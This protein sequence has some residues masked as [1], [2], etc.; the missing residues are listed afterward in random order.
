[1]PHDTRPCDICGTTYAPMYWGPKRKSRTCSRACMALLNRAESS[2]A[3]SSE[4]AKARAGRTCAVCGTVFDP[5]RSDNNHCTLACRR[6]ANAAYQAALRVPKRYMVEC[7]ECGET[8]EACVSTAYLC[9]QRCRRNRHFRLNPGAKRQAEA[10][11]AGWRSTGRITARDWERTLRRYASRCAYC[12]ASGKMTMDHVVPLSRGG[13][14]TIGN[15]LPV[16]GPCNFRKGTR[17][18]TEWRQSRAGGQRY[19]GSTTDGRGC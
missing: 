9:G 11:R 19:G 3:V 7:A 15:V 16:C 14:H 4:R 2:A 18:I 10:R 8:F 6:A 5:G 12:G 13:T 17:C 1:M